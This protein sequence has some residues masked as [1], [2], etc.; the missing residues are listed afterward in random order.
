MATRKTTA[1]KAA[2]TNQKAAAK[3][4]AAKQEPKDNPVSNETTRAATTSEQADHARVTS[5][6]TDVQRFGDADTET[7]KSA[8]GTAQLAYATGQSGS[9]DASTQRL[10]AV[11]QAVAERDKIVQQA[12]DEA[13]RAE[14]V[15]SANVAEVMT[16]LQSAPKA[17]VTN[18]MQQPL[19]V[20]DVGIHPDVTSPTNLYAMQ[21]PAL[22]GTGV[23]DP[24]DL[25]PG[26]DMSPS[27]PISSSNILPTPTK[28]G[29]PFSKL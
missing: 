24:R 2:A 25:A 28:P 4:T 16:D 22:P 8:A 3:R 10:S 15:E 5:G 18:A 27:P 13:K 20:A 9:T 26:Q 19:A 1:K 23:A 7:Q 29:T 6:E 12:A 21:N 17:P 14:Q 11:E